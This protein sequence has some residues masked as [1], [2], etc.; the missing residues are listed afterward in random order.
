[1]TCGGEE[2]EVKE[3]EQAAKVNHGTLQCAC[4]SRGSPKPELN[5][6]GTEES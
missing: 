6:V 3:V 1:M 2:E 4:G 5:V